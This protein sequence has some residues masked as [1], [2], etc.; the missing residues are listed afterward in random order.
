MIK[1]HTALK[2]DA[3]KVV[4]RV[5]V[6]GWRE[7]L[8]IP[9]LGIPAVKAKLDTGARTSSLHTYT[10]ETFRERGCLMV[11]F[12]IHPLQRRRDVEL[13]C[14]TPVVD[15]RMVTDSGGHRELRYVIRTQVSMADRQWP[16]E[17]TLTNR[18]TMTFR[19]LLGRSAMAGRF[20]VDSNRSYLTGKFLSNAY[21]TKKKKRRHV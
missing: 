19:M 20:L 12:G 11:R 9:G 8:S 4:P 1:K 18:D 13:F 14:V 10:L 6:V 2:K 7:W 5:L 15:Q 16:I 21:R 3:D 17:V